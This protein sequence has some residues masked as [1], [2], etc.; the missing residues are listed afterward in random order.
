M[1]TIVFPATNRV[2]L[3]RQQLLL[4]ELRKHFNVLIFQPTTAPDTKAVFSIFCAVEFNN[5]LAQH[6]VDAVLI[7]GDRYEMLGLAMVAAYRGLTILHIEGGDLSGAIDNKVRYAITHL[8]DYHFCTNDESLS[9]LIQNGVD[10]NTVW[11]YGSLDVEFAK[12][13][14]A[15]KAIKNF[16]LEPYILVVY[17]PID[18]EN[19]NELERALAQFNHKIINIA[20][21]NDYGKQFGSEQ[22]SPEEYINLITLASCCVGNSSSFLKEASIL[23]T[24]VVNVGDRQQKRLK[25]KNVVDAPCKSGRIRAAID[26]QLDNKFEPD[27]V[28]YKPDTSKN[29][30]KQLT[31]IM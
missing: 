23:G 22:Y 1:K 29:I 9:R 14:V 11:N 13:V 28:Y 30:A 4:N 3:A 19:E 26:F 27:Y 10:P 8:S 6:H 25:P 16:M 24:P 18:G 15:D 12:S 20:S 21:N 31:Q 2:H 5:F 17:H 7:R